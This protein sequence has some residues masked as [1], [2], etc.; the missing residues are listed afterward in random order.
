M[1]TIMGKV[2]KEPLRLVVIVAN[3]LEKKITDYS[4]SLQIY[5]NWVGK[6]FAE[7][8]L[9]VREDFEFR[10]FEIAVHNCAVSEYRKTY[11]AIK[12]NK[13]DIYLV[14]FVGAFSH[15]ASC[16]TSE[17]L[18]YFV[19][20]EK[21]MQSLPA[22]LTNEEQW[23]RKNRSS[24][25]ELLSHLLH[26]ICHTLG[27]FHADS[28]IMNK[29]IEMLPNDEARLKNIKFLNF[30]DKKSLTIICESMSIITTLKPRRS[31]GF[32]RGVLTYLSDQSIAA[33]F[34]VKGNGYMN[35]S[36]EEF[37]YLDAKKSYSHNAPHGW[38]KFVVVHFCGHIYRYD[39]LDV[40]SRKKC[41]R[42]IEF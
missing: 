22:T 15:L 3:Q 29:H 25:S 28:G 26:E 18:N 30:L 7:M 24:L 17:F 5:V 21:F 16:A 42:A 1:S 27:A 35:E 4:K 13:P 2:D 33:V 8:F 19:I 9:S 12:R 38:E 32:E 10:G 39:K 23:T 31:I 20:P 6:Q 34:F 36:Y 37:T 40:T 41:S 14:F 11:Q